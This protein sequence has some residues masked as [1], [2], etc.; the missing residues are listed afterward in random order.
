[1]MARE[2]GLSFYKYDIATKHPVKSC[3]ANTRLNWVGQ[4]PNSLAR[5]CPCKHGRNAR[6]LS[7][8]PPFSHQDDE[9]YKKTSHAGGLFMLY[10]I[11]KLL[12]VHTAR[13]GITGRD[14]NLNRNG[15]AINRVS[16]R[17]TTLGY[18]SLAR[19]LT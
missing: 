11:M 4:S 3:I 6:L 14:F 7:C 10:S 1:M 9:A 17:H 19:N 18:I 8:L 15:I 16:N 2:S 5:L 13:N 12:P